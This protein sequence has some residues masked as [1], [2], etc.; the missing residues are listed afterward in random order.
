M[1]QLKLL[2]LAFLCVLLLSTSAFAQVADG[3]KHFEKDG[4]AFDYPAN[5]KLT[6]STVDDVQR[7][8]I[9]A[10]DGEAEIGVVVALGADQC[11]FQAAGKM[12]TSN[13]LEHVATRIR[14]VRPIQTEPVKSQVG[15]LEIE[16]LMVRGVFKNDL[17]RSEI[18]SFRLKLH[19]VSLAYLRV[20]GNAPG[21]EAWELVRK[22]LAIASP[23]MGAT[24]KSEGTNSAGVLN[25]RA[26][27]LVQ[28]PYPAIARMSH[29][30]GTV[31]V[32]VIIDEAGEVISAR[33]ISGHPLLQAASV[34]AAK[35][36]KFS[37]TKL[38][39]EPV[40]VAGIIVYNFVV[41]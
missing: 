12:T 4:L 25:G 34:G 37:P 32:Q 31:E 2:V 35:A 33:A 27:H 11:D 19:I 14:A 5:W 8:T 15:P 13:W 30:Q 7:I 36:S 41:Q 16:G 10:E 38:C 18:F 24:T 23:V 9:A 17:A 3:N 29:A 26:I 6:D 21:E 39:G 1:K 40:R 22:T 20:D 28:P